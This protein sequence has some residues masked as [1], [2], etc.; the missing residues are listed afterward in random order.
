MEAVYSLLL[1]VAALFGVKYLFQKS[2]ADAIV[3][4]LNIKDRTE[5]TKEIAQL[6]QE[7]KDA[8]LDY[9][10]ALDRHR[11]IKSNTEPGRD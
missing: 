3:A 5:E 10:T 4:Q 8:K 7:I 9:K 1:I 6:E 2:K 11:N